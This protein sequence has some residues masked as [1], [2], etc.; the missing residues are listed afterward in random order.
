MRGV[1][2]S[3][4]VPGISASMSCWPPTASRGR[5]AS[6]STT[7]PSPPSHCVKLR[8][9]SS[10]RGIASMSVSTVAPVVVNPDIDSKYASTG[11]WSCGSETT[12]YGIAPNAATASQVRVTTRKP[13]RQPTSSWLGVSRARTVATA[14][15]AKNA[16]TYGA[17]DSP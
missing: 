3:T 5:I 10:A 6:A 17:I 15:V 12:R 1:S 2:F 8:H 14:Y 9:R 13:S 11:W 4:P 16:T 7:I